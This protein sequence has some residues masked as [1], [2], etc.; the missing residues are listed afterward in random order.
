M[1]WSLLLRGHPVANLSPTPGMEGTHL[2]E[3]PVQTLPQS[4]PQGTIPDGTAPQS[5]LGRAPSAPG[6]QDRAGPAEVARLGTGEGQVDRAGT[7]DPPPSLKLGQASNKTTPSG[8][9]VQEVQRVPESPL[10]EHSCQP[11][12]LQITAVPPRGAPGSNSVTFRASQI[13]LSVESG[14]PVPTGAAVSFCRGR[15]PPGPVTACFPASPTHRLRDNGPA[16]ATLP[17]TQ[18]T[19]TSTQLSVRATVRAARG[20]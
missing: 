17:P 6:P 14:A 3:F 19:R 11:P 12:G 7:L 5:D 16:G 20:Q 2:V 10:K 9:C 13:R 1:S 18:Q 8:P 4:Q 15:G